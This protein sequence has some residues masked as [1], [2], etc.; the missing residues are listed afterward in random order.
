MII[1]FFIGLTSKK[2]NYWKGGGKKTCGNNGLKV[3]NCNLLG[4]AWLEN[5]KIEKGSDNINILHGHV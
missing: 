4:V 1:L 2:V 3:L 5:I